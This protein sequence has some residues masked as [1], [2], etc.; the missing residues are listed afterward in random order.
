MQELHNAR[1]L[2]KPRGGHVHLFRLFV[3]GREEAPA[4][5]R[6]LPT[7]AVFFATLG[8]LLRVVLAAEGDWAIECLRQPN[9]P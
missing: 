1:P 4:V 6:V 8:A 3:A 5:A 7:G 2:E 9:D